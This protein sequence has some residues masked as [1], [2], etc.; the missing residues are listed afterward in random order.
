[1]TVPVEISEDTWVVLHYRILLEDGTVAE[2]TLDA[3]PIEFVMGDGTLE[4]GVELALYGKVKGEKEKIKIGP[5]IAYG[6]PDEDLKV[7]MAKTDFPDEMQVKPGMIIS[8]T[9]PSG[10]EIAG[11]ILEDLGDGFTVDLNHPLAGHEFDFEFE[12]IDIKPAPEKT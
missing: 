1:M 9:T 12:V 11:A 4:S 6:Y 8:F 5:E 10:E 7:K 2:S 3:E